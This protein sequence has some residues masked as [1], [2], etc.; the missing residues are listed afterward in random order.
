MNDINH[1][2]S[3]DVQLTGKG[4]LSISSTV[5]MTQQRILR[6]ILTNS[7]SPDGPPD[8]IWNPE[9]GCGAS[10]YVGET[11]N[12]LTEL[13]TIIIGQ[14]KLEEGVA[15]LPIPEVT[16]V[17]TSTILTITIKYVDI[18]T[19]TPQTFTFETGGAV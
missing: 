18:S 10:K 19:G 6:R 2:F 8:Y 16:L 7:A 3:G 14:L 12:K 9:Y 5:I 17:T 13:K 1:W 11:I 4:D 15:Q